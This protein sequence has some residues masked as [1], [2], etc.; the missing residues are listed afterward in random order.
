[1][2]WKIKFMFETTNQIELLIVSPWNPI[3]IPLNPYDIPWKPTEGAAPA[4]TSALEDLAH[5]RRPRGSLVGNGNQ[6]DP[7]ISIVKASVYI[8]CN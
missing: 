3:E 8:N 6:W 4:R 5:A 7:I 1:M 2:L